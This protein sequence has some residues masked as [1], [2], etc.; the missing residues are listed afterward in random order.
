MEPE[1][2][3]LEF[4]FSQFSA[5][6]SPND[7]NRQYLQQQNEEINMLKQ[8]TPFKDFNEIKAEE[9]TGTSLN[10][11][12]ESPH[13]NQSNIFF[14]NEFYSG[15]R[16][17]ETK[18]QEEKNESAS[19]VRRRDDELD[20]ILSLMN[21]NAQSPQKHL[22]LQRKN[23]EITKHNE[24]QVLTIS[25]FL[26]GGASTL[27]PSF[28]VMKEALLEM[29]SGGGENLSQQQTTKP[30]TTKLKKR[31]KRKRITSTKSSSYKSAMLLQTKG[32]M[33][34]RQ[35]NYSLSPPTLFG[36]I[37]VIVR[38]VMDGIDP[39]SDVKS[40]SISLQTP[41]QSYDPSLE[42]LFK[43]DQ[44]T[45]LS[46]HF[47]DLF[48]AP[49]TNPETLGKIEEFLTSSSSSSS[50]AVFINLK[51]NSPHNNNN[52]MNST[53]DSCD[54]SQDTRAT[55]KVKREEEEEGSSSLVRNDDDSWKTKKKNHLNHPKNSARLT[56]LSHLPPSDGIPVSCH[57]EI[58]KITT[59][60]N[61]S[62]N[63]KKKKRK[64]SKKSDEI[65]KKQMMKREETRVLIN[66]RLATVVGKMQRCLE[67]GFY[68]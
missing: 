46:S 53:K 64:T 1:A 68:F 6:D 45:L 15:K 57:L 58:S 59:T 51:A 63:N 50:L 19:I 66:I 32:V 61:E 20:E 42:E 7:L 29:K 35:K 9:L 18:G 21:K 56:R 38:V 49:Y 13:Q 2:P 16:S 34:Q 27:S 23:Q 31:K 44:D 52:N 10:C 25:P 28:N 43:Y 26:M 48:T 47:F 40:S 5:H 62:N 67:A 60:S 24:D 33:I 12:F 17:S 3:K 41:I 11:V 22:L 55:K 36:G 65:K 30:S 39:T 8:L 4:I 14:P 54:S 37:R